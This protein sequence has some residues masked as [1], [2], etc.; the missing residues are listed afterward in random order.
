MLHCASYSCSVFSSFILAAF[1]LAAFLN[2]LLQSCVCFCLL[3]VGLS[4]ADCIGQLLQ[5]NRV[6]EPRDGAD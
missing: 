2:F 4:G 5:V 3:T 1:V 6:M